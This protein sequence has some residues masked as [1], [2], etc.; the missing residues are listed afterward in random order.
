MICSGRPIVVLQ[1]STK[2]HQLMLH[3]IS[4]VLLTRS[5]PCRYSEEFNPCR[6]EFDL[7]TRCQQWYYPNMNYHQLGNSMT[8]SNDF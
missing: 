1:F 8:L 2:I 7:V 6:V 4:I 5:T 3:V